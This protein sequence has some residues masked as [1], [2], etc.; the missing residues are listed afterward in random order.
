MY[1]AIECFVQF[2][3]CYRIIGKVEVLQVNAY[4]Y[5]T[6]N[7]YY[8]NIRKKISVVYYT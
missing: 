8:S 5:R 6:L 3:Y 2:D 1:N 7:A 4:C